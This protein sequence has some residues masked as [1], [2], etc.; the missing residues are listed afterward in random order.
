MR[1]RSRNR[2]LAILKTYK[3][4]SK[5]IGWRKNQKRKNDLNLKSNMNMKLDTIRSRKSND[6][7]FT[8]FYG[9]D[10]LFFLW[11]WH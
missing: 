3:L 7:L 6:N 5:M 9:S 2:R 11:V 1:M 4:T 10:F 8:V